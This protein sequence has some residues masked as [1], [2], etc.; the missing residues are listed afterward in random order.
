MKRRTL[1]A[2]S[3]A[4]ALPTLWLHAHAQTRAALTPT[5]AQT[6]GPF[7][8]IAELADSDFDLLRNGTLN[9]A[10]GQPCWLEGVVHDSNARPVA[11]AIVEIWQCDEA[12][13]Y[14][15]PADRGATPV[16]FQGFGR[17]QVAAD[18][19][20]RFRT[21]KPAPYSGR[22]PHIHLKVK[23]D[24]RELLTTQMYVEGDSGNA[25]DFLWRR[26]SA[27]QRAAL[28][29]SFVR[30]SDGWRAEFPV[31]VAV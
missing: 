5:P 11:G 25:N 28:T 18:G 1:L 10:L 9:Y 13:H 15:H 23:L 21:I 26:L 24:K 12:G 31:V 2:A 19:R 8:P 29:R 3:S 30:A 14:R 6:E 7:Y 22:T 17:V 16:E 27:E 20:Y 4:A